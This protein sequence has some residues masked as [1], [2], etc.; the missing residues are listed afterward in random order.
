MVIGGRVGG[1]GGRVVTG[2][3]VGGGAVTGGNDVGSGL[4]VSTA[5]APT[6]LSVMLAIS[7]QYDMPSDTGAALAMPMTSLVEVGRLSGTGV[8]PDVGCMHARRIHVWHIF[9]D[10]FCEVL[11]YICA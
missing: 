7:C 8:T 5:M 4:G 6:M 2:G 1:G 3:R 9:F 10:F 11:E